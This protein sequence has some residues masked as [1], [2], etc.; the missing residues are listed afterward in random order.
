MSRETPPRRASD[1]NSVD[2]T[3]SSSKRRKRTNGNEVSKSSD[4][5]QD[6]ASDI[7]GDLKIASASFGKMAEPMERQAKK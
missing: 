3:S 6:M 2:S 5:F 4:P 1:R 7:R